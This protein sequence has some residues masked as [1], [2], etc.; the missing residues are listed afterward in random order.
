MKTRNWLLLSLIMIIPLVSPAQQSPLN[1]DPSVKTGILNNGFRYY[2]KRNQEPAKR[3][4]I[5][6]ANKVGSILEQPE[7]Q[8]IAHFIEHM[9]FNG[10]KHFPKNELIGYLERSGVKFGADL[11]AFTSY[12]ETIYQ[13]PIPTDNAELWKNGLQ[14]MRDWAADA[15]ID[16]E[17]FNQERGVILEEKRQRTDAASRLAAQYQPILFDQSLYAA[18]MPIG[19]TEVIQHADVDLARNFYKRWYRPDLQALIIVGDINVEEV[20][21]QVVGL[22]SDLKQP[23]PLVPR[24]QQTI[25]LKNAKDFMKLTDPELGQYYFRFYFKR[26]ALSM[27]TDEDFK[28]SLVRQLTNMLFQNRM[29]ELFNKDKPPYLQ[30]SGGISPLIANIDALALTVSLD[31][32]KL[33]AGF[34]V[35][36][37]EVTQMKRFGFTVE[38]L[39]SVKDRLARS[40]ELQM[41]EK[42]KVKSSIYADEY[43]DHFL[44]GDVF[45]SV[46]DRNRLFNK[47]IGSIT[48]QETQQYLST[49]LGSSSNT[50]L[51]FGPEKGKALPD[52]QQLNNWIETAEKAALQPYKSEVVATTLL[53]N[54]PAS[55]KIIQE[56]QIKEV[57]TYH[58]KL[59]NGI[60]IYAKPTEFKNSEVLF[61]GFSKGGISLYHQADYYSAKYATTFI[62]NSG[63]GDFDANQLDNVLNKKAIN[64]DPYIESSTEGFS[65]YSA[66]KDLSTA[67]EM[68]YL[69]MSAP[70]LDTARFNTIIAKSKSAF[71]NRTPNAQQDLTDT[72]TYVLSS[73]HPRRKPISITDFDK[74]DPVKVRA[75]FLERFA[76]PADFTFVF[77]GNF[78]VDSLKMFTQQYLGAL[79]PKGKPE[80]PV[81][82]KIRVP[83]GYLRKDL[84]GDKSNK[85]TVQMVI[86]GTYKYANEANRYL[87]LL[88]STLQLRL[89]TRLREV[90]GGTYSPGVYLTK[91]K[92]PVNFYS[93]SVSFE[94]DPLRMEKLIQAANDEMDN[95]A[96]SGVSNEELQKF[97]MEQTRANELNLRSNQFW[98]SY[99][100]NS[101]K[102]EEPLGS[103]YQY[104]EELSKM[105]SKESK[106]YSQQF[107][108]R[109]NEIIFTLRP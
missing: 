43:L 45:L 7:E 97:I 102:E 40:M 77:T 41:A 44:K 100:E 85:A 33:K 92:W 96:K 5:Y 87:E 78:N 107:L 80:V 9:N 57:N 74:I 24:P 48:E 109:K 32:E 1:N 99:L 58:W 66:S 94:C 76:N 59:S 90:E 11:N 36:W 98:T 91:D 101:L 83:R 39:Q 86:S 21:K 105:T 12:D 73:Y 67:L 46:E 37:Q 61:S 103:I 3:A 29:R 27:K 52:Q 42:N 17:A 25:T 14:I 38:E 20:E 6:L 10:T 75:I 18:R 54:K 56:E 65:G 31:P 70:R 34:N 53:K 106:T 8:G 68:V 71:R 26:P 55:G 104:P 2:I 23:A 81:D 22:F 50:M 60:N 13:L 16:A 72:I 15:T 4:T 88:K 89:T 62:V 47:Y 64:V 108:N 95:L 82:L 35:F 30:A 28:E 63:L 84:R 19:K 49:F 69:Y 93:M 51:V 79:P